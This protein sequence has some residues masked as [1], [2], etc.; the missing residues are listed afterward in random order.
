[1]LKDRVVIVTGSAQGIGKHAARTFAHEQAKIVIADF[2]EE[3][4]KKTAAELGKLA[5]TLAILV[6]VR[7]E[8]S[9]KRMVDQ[10]MNRFGKS[11]CISTTL[12]SCPTLLGV[13]RVGRASVRCRWISGIASCK[14]ISMGLSLGQSMC[15]LTWK[16]E[17]PG[18][19]SISTVA[20]A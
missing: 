14:R 13:F 19:L 11:M 3:N 18:T 1:M 9:L 16:R 5:E 6:D 4:A 15:F 17:K 2:N 12:L 10:V 20:A 7:D 8:D